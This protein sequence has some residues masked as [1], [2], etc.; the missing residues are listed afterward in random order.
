MNGRRQRAGIGPAF[1]ALFLIATP[2]L[3]LAAAG[4]WAP[5]QIL[6]SGGADALRR[7]PESASAVRRM[8]AAAHAAH[9]A[10]RVRAGLHALAR[11]GYAPSRAT[12]DLLSPYLAPEEQAGLARRFAANGAAAGAS[13]LYA[14]VPP[15]RRLVEGIARDPR[16]GR[17]FAG[18]VVGRELLVFDH[19]G[20]RAVPGVDA[21]SLFGMAVDAP[22]RR[23][24]IAS[25]ALDQ[26]PHPEAA[27]RGLIA[28]DVDKLRVVRRVALAGSPGDLAI[29]RDGT[30]YASDPVD[31]TLFRLRPGA[32]ASVLVP[33][34]RFRSP[35][36]LVLS[37]DERRL[38]VAD[39][40]YG[41]GIVDLASGHIGRLAARGPAML[42]G[43][44]GMIGDRGALIA[45]QNGVSPHRIVRLRLD[46]AGATVTRVDIVESANPAWGEPSLGTIAGGDLLYVADGQWERYGA[47]GAET[48]AARPTPIR[49]VRLIEAG[50]HRSRRA[51]VA[52][53][54][55]RQ[56]SGRVERTRDRHAGRRFLLSVGS[57][58]GWFASHRTTFLTGSGT[59]HRVM[60]L[61]DE[62][63][64]S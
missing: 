10:A 61:P 64:M 44:D 51:R 24:W 16:T 27:F 34:G 6:K 11:M 14:S 62:C 30:V 19:C 58:Q 36:G 4:D 57:R 55:E 53:G 43:V 59:D 32:P 39:Y 7:F 12:I 33:A 46:R 3:P 20:W 26:T 28:V 40:A 41:I 37:P 8:L 23:L 45:I 22:G 50:L 9:D 63:I 13:R 35:Q 48:G 25:G 2:A 18:T 42:D 17:L 47:G 29:G 5:A 49:A 21:G 56:R 31:G 38:Y 1:L 54:D 15:E 52:A 60:R